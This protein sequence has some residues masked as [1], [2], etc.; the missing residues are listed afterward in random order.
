[1]E[2]GE[3]DLGGGAGA[4]EAGIALEDG[5]LYAALGEGDGG[6]ETVGPRADDVGS[7]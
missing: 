3:G 4:A 7:A 1:M 6:G 5:D 2:A